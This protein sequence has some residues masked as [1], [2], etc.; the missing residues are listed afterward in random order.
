MSEIWKDIKGYEGR[1]KISDQGKVWSLV[2]NK[3]MRPCV[4]ADG[5][6][7]IGLRKDGKSRS[8]GIHQLLYLTFIGDYDYSQGEVVDH[9][10]GNKLN[11]SLDNF[12][13]LSNRDNMWKGRGRRKPCLPPNV[14]MSP[15]GK[16][17]VKVGGKTIGM[18]DTFTQALVA[19]K[20][21]ENEEL[22]KVA[23]P[24]VRQRHNITPDGYKECP[25]CHEVKPLSEYAMYKGHVKT[26]KCKDCDREY[27]LFW[28]RKRREEK[29][30]RKQ[31]IK[32][33][34]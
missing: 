3:E 34:L 14:S 15:D 2:T 7:R 30:M 19:Q 1:Y 25:I 16:Y 23:L 18:F 31:K 12:Q 28:N 8:F 9:I 17:L 11:N 10:D 27:K 4:T 13:L 26:G 20:E 24:H 21:I 22:D 33:E 6:L 32:N 5:Y 29:R